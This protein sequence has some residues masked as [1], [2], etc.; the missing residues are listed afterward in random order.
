MKPSIALL[1]TAFAAALTL[2]ATAPSWAQDAKS[3]CAL[4]IASG[5]AGKIYELV[6]RDIQADCGRTVPVCSVASTGGLQNLSMLSAN[7][8]DLG[9]VQ[10]DTLKDMK[11]GDENIKALE[12]VMPLHANLLHVL[13]LAKGSLVNVTYIRGVPVPMTGSM[14]TI[15]KFSEL[16][17]MTVAVVGSAQHMGQSLERQLG[18]GMKFV[19]AESDDQALTLLNNGQI[20]AIF[21][22]GGWPLPSV[23]RIK[24]NAGL[25]LVDFDLKP[26]APY[27]VVKRNYQNLDAFNLSFLGVPNMLVTRPFKAGGPMAGHVSTLRSCIRQRLDEL[28]EGRYQPIW[29]EIKDPNEFYGVKPFAVGPVSSAKGK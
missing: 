22:L 16:K 8:A 12:A 19:V 17:G 15:R 10:I 6:V 21:T 25:Q 20:Q 24:N 1:H 2:A 26:Q 28:Q 4:R 27:T 29:K 3:E 9:I 7:E 11:E 14:F 5:P 13:S 23:A 18:Y